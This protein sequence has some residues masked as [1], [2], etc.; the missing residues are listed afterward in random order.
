MNQTTHDIDFLPTDVKRRR[1]RRHGRSWRV[2]VIAAALGL[3]VMVAIGQSRTL[4]QIQQ[5]VAQVEPERKLLD[6]RQV[7]LDQLREQLAKTDARAELVAYMGHP[8]PKTQLLAAAL[9][10]LPDAVVYN[11]IRITHEDLSGQA[12]RKPQGDA[13]DEDLTRLEPAQRD[14]RLLQQECD[15]AV[16]AITLEGNTTDGIEL[17]RYM[18]DLNHVPLLD[19]VELHSLESTGEES[20]AKFRFEARLTVRPGFGQR[21][22]PDGA[23][24]QL[25][26]TAPPAEPGLSESHQP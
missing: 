18:D 17:H 9:N 4:H 11:A 5:R 19:K 22:G 1:T 14:L 13:A 8:W 12:A 16:V 7:Q 3:C 6:A 2:I 26:Q 20:L 24:R 25:V 15:F 23:S 10:S 21:G